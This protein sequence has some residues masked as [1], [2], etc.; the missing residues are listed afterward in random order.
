VTCQNAAY[1]ALQGLFRAR[2]ISPDGWNCY[3]II[4]HSK[5]YYFN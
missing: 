4:Y 1:S 2:Y 5:K 3:F